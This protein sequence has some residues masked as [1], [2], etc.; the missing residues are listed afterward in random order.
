MWGVDDCFF[1]V[2]SLLLDVSIGCVSYSFQNVSFFSTV[3]FGLV[4]MYVLLSFVV[5]DKFSWSDDKWNCHLVI[6]L[7]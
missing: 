2:V 7:R 6:G 5:G 1:I 3:A 4:I